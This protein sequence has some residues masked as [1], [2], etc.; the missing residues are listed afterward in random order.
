V[1][2]RRDA[3]ELAL[4]RAAERLDLPLLAVCRGLQLLNVAWGGTLWQDLPSERPS[5]VLHEQPGARDARTHQVDVEPESRLARA[6]GT[7]QLACNSF[8]HQAIRELAP[9]LSVV[10][11]AADGVIEG[12]ESEPERGWVIGVQWHPEEFHGERQAPDQRLFEALVRE[13]AREPSN[14]S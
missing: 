6:L 9:G 4:V 11:R 2:S 10:A 13:A 12:V 3:F 1:D 7:A 14:R 5:G 8:H